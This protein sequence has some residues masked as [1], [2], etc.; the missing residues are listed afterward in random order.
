[1]RRKSSFSLATVVLAALLPSAVAAQRD[2]AISAPPAISV[3]DL[4]VVEGNGG[5]P[6]AVFTLRLL[7]ASARRV[8]IRFATA[9]G[10]ARAGADYFARSGG[11]RL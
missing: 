9:D 7:R 4:A 6:D 1:M 3:R 2:S 5:T 8:S 10:S 11:R